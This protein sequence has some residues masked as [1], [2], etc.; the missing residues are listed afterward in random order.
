M[1]WRINYRFPDDDD[2]I[3]GPAFVVTSPLP[4]SEKPKAEESD[5]PKP[6]KRP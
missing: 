3:F 2:P 4:K 1:R 6:E 5:K